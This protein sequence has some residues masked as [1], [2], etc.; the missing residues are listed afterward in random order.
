M[1]VIYYPAENLPKPID[2]AVITIGVFDGLHKGHLCLLKEVL[3][4]SRKIKGKSLVITFW[5]HPQRERLIYSLSHRLKL[6]EKLNMD[7][8]VVTRFSSKFRD[9]SP[10]RFF[11]E[12]ILKISRP[13]CIVVGENF[14]F[15]KGACGDTELLKKFSLKYDFRLKVI[16]PL[17]L[18]NRII[19]STYIRKLILKGKIKE[20][21]NWLVFPFSIWG[22]VIRGMGLAKN[23]GFPTANLATDNEIL[24]AFGV[25]LVRARLADKILPAVCYI[26]DRPTFN[27][28]ILSKRI[29]FELHLLNFK[30]NLYGKILEVEFIKRLRPQ[31]KFPQPNLLIQR[32]KRDIQIARHFFN[33]I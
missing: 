3:R 27:D 14:R 32:I 16:P 19:S 24:P 30:K 25:Y 29:S 8:C 7:I 28:K 2:R 12:V 9:M 22:R 11:E 13:Y 1:K 10:Q 20:A 18:K 5:P 33:L 6:L 21:S 31:K 15:G 4:Y 26:G 23:L 17:K